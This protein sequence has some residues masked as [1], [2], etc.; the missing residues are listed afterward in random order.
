MSS[1]NLKMR[2]LIK[3]EELSEEDKKI[4]MDIRKNIDDILNDKENFQDIL[5][6]MYRKA[7]KLVRSE[8]YDIAVEKEELERPVFS[9][10]VYAR[11]VTRAT[12]LD[13]LIVYEMLFK[14][15]Q[16]YPFAE[17]CEI[18]NLD[19]NPLISK[20]GHRLLEDMFKNYKKLYKN[21]EFIFIEADKSFQNEFTDDMEPYVEFDGGSDV[22]RYSNMVN[23]LLKYSYP[24]RIARIEKETKSYVS[25]LKNLSINEQM[26]L[27]YAIRRAGVKCLIYGKMGF[28]MASYDGT[29]SYT[30][31]KFDEEVETLKATIRKKW[32]SSDK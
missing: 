30:R 10:F 16:M 31:E 20:S 9:P 13:T 2:G 28:Y 32:K 14:F 25:S 12:S 11:S 8:L 19:I 18:R 3:M 24:K 27:E 4:L 1:L 29:S 15:D 23:Y 22:M 17:Y 26:E 7:R 6:S 5:G 21:K